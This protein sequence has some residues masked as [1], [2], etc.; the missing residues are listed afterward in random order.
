[1][2]IITGAMTFAWV[3]VANGKMQAEL[4]AK[5]RKAIYHTDAGR[6]SGS[7]GTVVLQYLPHELVGN[8]FM[9]VSSC[10]YTTES[11]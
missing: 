3:L 9:E 7:S 4:M 6:R 5:Y 2:A 1:M 8:Y 10:D 11:I